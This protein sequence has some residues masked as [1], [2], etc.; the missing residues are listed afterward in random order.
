MK[1]EFKF[2]DGRKI[3]CCAKLHKIGEQKPYFSLTGEILDQN[4]KFESVGCIH[5]EIIRIWPDLKIL[6]D[7]HLSDGNGIPMHAFEN[8]FYFSG[9]YQKE[10]PDARSPKKLA[11]H[12][13]ITEKQS[14]KICVQITKNPD[15]EIFHKICWRN[16]PRWNREAK[17]AIKKFNLKVENE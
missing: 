6:V 3:T 12:L 4:G 5:E 2:S 11:N 15:K 17:K 10:F 8:G 13:R 1:K 9:G 16:L 7:L 14:N